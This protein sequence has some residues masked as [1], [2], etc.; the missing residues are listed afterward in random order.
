MARVPLTTMLDW[1]KKGSEE[2]YDKAK[3]DP[4]LFKPGEGIDDVPDGNDD[5]L[6]DDPEEDPEGDEE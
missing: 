3:N 6:K 5:M 4:K 2:E 1:M